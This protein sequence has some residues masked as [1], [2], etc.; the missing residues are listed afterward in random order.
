MTRENGRLAIIIV[1]HN[2]AHWLAPC[3]SSVYA[4][5]G[6]LDVDIVVVDSGST[7]DTVDL[8][9]REFP[10]VRVL[11]TEN[12]GFASANNRGL[13]IVD[14]EWVLFLNPDTRILS[15]TLEELVSLL[16]ARPTVGL[17][18]VRQVDESGV[19]DPTIRRFPNAVRTLSVSLGAERLP[20]HASW[21]G[22]RELDVA[23]Y[24]RETR[25][26]WT[27]GSFMLARKAAIDDVGRDG[28]ALLLSTARRPTSVF[29]CGRPAGTLSIFP[30]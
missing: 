15:G 2:S 30:R 8:V 29:E 13:E 18:G 16:R 20:F 3:L 24:D 14:A 26:D 25:C 12:R 22:E 9:R 23:L 11:P 27:V 21:L 17:A 6:N 4:N 19:M 7:D 5:S 10:D 1:S 28:R